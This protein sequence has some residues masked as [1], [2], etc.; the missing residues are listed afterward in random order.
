VRQTLLAQRDRLERLLLTERDWALGDWRTLYLDHP[1]LGILA[2]PL[3]WTFADAERTALG[4]WHDG[5]LVDAADQP[6]DWLGDAT[7]VRLWHPIASPADTV[8][9][10]RQW[11]ERHSLTQPFK[12]AHREVYVVTDAERAAGTASRRFAEHILRQHQFRALCNQRGWRYGLQG[13]FDGAETGTPTLELPR[14][15]LRAELDVEPIEED[16][17]MSA[18]GIFLYVLTEDVRFVRPAPQSDS[19]PRTKQQRLSRIMAALREGGLKSLT[20]D[21]IFPG[22]TPDEPVPLAEVPPIVFSE[23]MRDVDLFVSAASVGADP[24]WLDTAPA[25]YVDYWSRF[26]F[27]DLAPSAQTRRAALERLLPRL[28]IAERCTLI[29]R[30]LVVRGDLRTYNIHLGSGNVQMEPNSQYLCIVPRGGIGI[31]GE[32]GHLYLPFDEDSVLSLILSKA[33]LL[34][35]DRAIKDPTILRQIQPN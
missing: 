26:S 14:W 31:P 17:M 1:L 30:F 25:R 13:S 9:A 34:A 11:L 6:L 35:D 18:N 33:F 2:R 32:S 27:G 28:K 21:T 12:Q 20:L 15:G 8:L 4:A 10:W 29:D 24:R 22:L 7:R 5:R 16:D 3:I 19:A 23:V